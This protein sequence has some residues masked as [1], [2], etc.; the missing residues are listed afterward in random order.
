[1]GLFFD[2]FPAIAFFIAYEVKGIYLATA[3]LILVTI[4]QTSY[5][6]IRY[7]KMDVLQCIIFLLVLVFGTATIWFRDAEILQWKVSIASWIMSGAFFIT[8]RFTKTPLIARML[9]SSIEL[10]RPTWLILN[11]CWSGFFLLLGIL[12]LIVAK[13]FSLNVWVHFKV[14]GILGLTVI[15]VL[16]QTLYLN[17]Q[18]KKTNIL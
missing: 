13:T 16:I 6:L 2:V 4:L 18:L 12:N 5:T 1:M 9:G 11:R 17:R 15:F 10:P 3:V 7:R 8:G 14:F